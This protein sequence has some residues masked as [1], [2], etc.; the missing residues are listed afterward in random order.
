[1]IAISLV[2]AGAQYPGTSWC[3][4]AVSSADCP[5]FLWIAY[6][7]QSKEKDG[8]LT[9]RFHIKG[10]DGYLAGQGDAKMS[11][12]AFY[13]SRRARGKG[14]CHRYPAAIKNE[15]GPPFLDITTGRFS[16]IELH[17]SALCGK[18]S[19]RAATV[20]FMFG[21]SGEQTT[22]PLPSA[23]ELRPQEPYLHLRPERGH[24]WMQT[25]QT[26]RFVYL[27]ASKGSGVVRVMEEQ[28]RVGSVEIDP[29]G[30]FSY[31]PAHDR[32]LDRA[33]PSA[34]KQAVLLVEEPTAQGIVSNTFTLLLHRSRYGHH[35][36][37]PG[38]ALF[39]LVALGVLFC[40]MR[41]RKRSAF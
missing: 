15:A 2:L 41:K 19:Y 18:R 5:A 40:V 30:A 38:L 9:Q 16:R 22:Q 32:K 37:L 1:M 33:G 29:Q 10:P 35:Q 7:P 20:L 6:G 8:S 24:Y 36:L 21:K 12:S 3:G 23:P 14:P 28:R 26:F 34:S 39:A 25:G 17:V 31:T 4:Q 11:L 27:G 13:L